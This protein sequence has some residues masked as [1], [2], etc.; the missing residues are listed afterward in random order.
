[1]GLSDVFENAVNVAFQ[2][3]VDFVKPGTYIVRKSDDGWGPDPILDP[4][5]DPPA[6]SPNEFDM[7]VIV[8]GLSQKDLANSKFFAQMQPTD[9]VIMVKGYDIKSNSIRVRNTDKFQIEFS[10]YTGEFDIIDHETD[11]AEALFIILLREVKNA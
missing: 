4:P 7:E 2:V 10:S 6:E 3:F 1:M 5:I 9:T 11:P 8:N